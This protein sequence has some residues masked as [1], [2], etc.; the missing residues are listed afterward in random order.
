MV[1]TKEEV[2]KIVENL[3]YDLLDEYM[4]EGYRRKV[5]IQ[6]SDGYRYDT[7]LN[8]IMRGRIPNFS[9]K[10]NPF[11]LENILKWCELNNKLFV[12]CKGNIYKGARE[13]LF[14]QCLKETCGEVF[15][16]SWND[17]YDGCGCPFC[18]G[19]RVGANNSLACLKPELAREWDYDKNKNTPNEYTEKS[20]EIVSWICSKCNHRWEAR[21]SNRSNGNG[22]PKCAND[23]KES[24]LANQLK[25][26][27]KEKYNSKN[28]YRI[29]KNTETNRWLPYDIYIPYGENP[30]VNGF[31]I[32]VHGEQHYNLCTWHKRQAKKN[33]TTPEE[34]F[35]Y[36]KYLDRFKQKFARKNGVYIE[37]DI[38]K[39]KIE[40]DAIEYIENILKQ[41]L[42]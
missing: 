17:I 29:L 27:F 40:Q 30:D 1:R 41:T 36:Q 42:L 23:R 7:Q 32:E 24:Q 31:Y 4:G 38:R 13:K 12:P 22:C 10:R 25:M 21:I 34:E 11:I 16:M 15:D 39:I 33:D 2:Q 26:Y 20:G 14:F 8:H 37:I 9:D 19:Y 6:D 35:E 28:E 5:I 3:G 18:R